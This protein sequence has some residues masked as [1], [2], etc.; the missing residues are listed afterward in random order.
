MKIMIENN[1]NTSPQ[2]IQEELHRIL[3]ETH[4]TLEDKLFVNCIINRKEDLTA[5][6]IS[7]GLDRGNK[8]ILFT[9]AKGYW[10]TLWKIARGLIKDLISKNPIGAMRDIDRDFD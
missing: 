9:S 1:P 3:E 7:I 10:S 5:V 4:K 6:T 2:D 8:E